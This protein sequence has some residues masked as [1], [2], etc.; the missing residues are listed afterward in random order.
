MTFTLEAIK[1]KAAAN[2]FKFYGMKGIYY[3]CQANKKPSFKTALYKYNHHYN[4][5]WIGK[6]AYQE[7]SEQDFFRLVDQYLDTVKKPN[8]FQA[9]PFL[10]A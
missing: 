9:M 4:L 8:E 6:Q 7:Y 3:L 5:V 2:G 1:E 10:T